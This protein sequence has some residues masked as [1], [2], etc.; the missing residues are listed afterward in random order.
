MSS[1]PRG[2][3]WHNPDCSKSREALR[4][5]RDAEATFTIREYL[6]DPPTRPELEALGQRLRLPAREWTRDVPSKQVVSDAE[7]LSAVIEKPSLLQRPIFEL[8]ERAIVARPPERVLEL[9]EEEKLAVARQMLEPARV[10][11]SLV[12]FTLAFSGSYLAYVFL[13]ERPRDEAEEAACLPPPA[14]APGVV[15][16]LPDGRLLMEDGSVRARHDEPK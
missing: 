3:L 6:V 8:G 11:W 13:I 9:L 10:N 15:Q 5:L 12:A 14:L 2:R 4:L 7:L 16:I 1:I